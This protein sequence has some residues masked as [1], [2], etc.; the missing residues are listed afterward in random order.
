MPSFVGGDGRVGEAGAGKVEIGRMK[1]TAG[2]FGVHTRSKRG[3]TRE[4]VRCAAARGHG[5][6][7]V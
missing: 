1:G 2:G 6:E 7:R 3:H 4:E 5:W